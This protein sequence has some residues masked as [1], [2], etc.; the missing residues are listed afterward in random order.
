MILEAILGRD[1]FPDPKAYGSSAGQPHGR[2]FVPLGS[3]LV[4]VPLPEG[5][6]R[7]G[8]RRCRQDELACLAIVRAQ[9]ASR[10]VV[11]DSREAAKL[12]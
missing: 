5:S 9:E 1:R 6:G 3:R 7:P 8:L 10:A 11:T 2:A 4:L 12:R